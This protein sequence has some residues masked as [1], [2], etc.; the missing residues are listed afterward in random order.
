MG[1]YPR[2]TI[3]ARGLA[4]VSFIVL[5]ALVYV[6]YTQATTQFGIISNAQTAATAARSVMSLLVNADASTRGYV[7]TGDQRY[8]ES[9][10]RARSELPAELDTLRRGAPPQQADLNDFLAAVDREEDVLRRTVEARRTG[11]FTAA[12]AL[13]ATNEGEIAMDRTRQAGEAMLAGARTRVLADRAAGL[14]RSRTTRYLMLFLFVFA[15]AL[16]TLAGFDTRRELRRRARA[17]QDLHTAYEAVEARVY[18]RTRELVDTNTRLET[19]ERHAQ[20]LAILRTDLLK[21]E[22]IARADAE[23][24]NRLKD[25]F[26]ATVSH[27]LRTPLNAIV[28]WAHLLKSGITDDQVKAASA[29]ERNA[30]AQAR[31]IDDLLDVSRL[32]K[33][34]FSLA[35]SSMDLR[36]SVYAALETVRPAAEAKHLDIQVVAPEPVIVRGD[37][38]RL[39]QVASSLL[40]NAVKFT[41]NGGHVTIEVERVGS[42]ARL[43]VSDSGE[44]IDPEFLPHVFEPFRQTASRRRPAGLGL[45]LAIVRQIVE[46]HGGTVV[47]GSD[48]INQG[49][50]FTIMMPYGDDQAAA[51]KEPT[52]EAITTAG[53]R[54]LI[55]EDD[56][57]SAVTLGTAL[58]HRGCTVRTARTAQECLDLFAE[59][60]PDVL[61]CD[62][63]LPD[64]D[65][66]SLLRRLR[67]RNRGGRFVPAI[68][69][70]A[71]SRDEDRSRTLAAGF[72]AHLSKPFEVEY[73]VDTVSRVVRQASS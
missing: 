17:E 9:Y 16:L 22:Q 47:A 30:F 25:E 62:I 63:G 58:L 4:L 73:L 64:D 70:T 65:G 69:V 2:V 41:P 23:M 45:G 49:S 51:T 1:V 34:R 15:T 43:R 54:V 36:A 48:G 38:V 53:L 72:A 18:Q 21:R 32:M 8:L 68:A 12:R 50:S 37:D 57:D 28:G 35:A 13:I 71:L 52:S 26:L 31:L 46:M 11:G 59:W 14:R 7:I 60:Q 42:R 40:A 39:Q 20:E 3:W 19:S 6:R 44:G 67:E 56:E 24:A 29:I 66:Y 55:A 61:V 33:G 27:E 10:D 5:A